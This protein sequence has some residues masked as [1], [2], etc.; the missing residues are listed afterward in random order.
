MR[1]PANLMRNAFAV[2]LMAVA[3][4]TS[5]VSYAQE[6]DLP[7]ND[8]ASPSSS[9]A[10]PPSGQAAQAEM[11]HFPSPFES[12]PEPGPGIMQEEDI[13]E[14]G[15]KVH[16]A[17]PILNCGYRDTNLPWTIMRQGWNAS[18]RPPEGPRNFGFAKAQEVHKIVDPLRLWHRTLGVAQLGNGCQ[19]DNGSTIAQARF[20]GFTCTWN[21]RFCAPAPWRRIS[22]RSV[23][24]NATREKLPD[25]WFIND[26]RLGNISLYC[27]NDDGTKPC[28]SWIHGALPYRP[29]DPN[30]F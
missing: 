22:V 16:S 24:N 10:S 15:G 21:E 20:L 30:D 29:D 1:R 28:P 18:E 26:K 27:I 6:A 23:E 14:T 17:F 19:W 25:Y 12:A 8:N 7:D 11:P 4:T 13:W 3:V 2:T 5:G 9:V